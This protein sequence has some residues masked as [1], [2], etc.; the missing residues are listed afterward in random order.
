[1]GLLRE[2]DMRVSDV[3]EAVG[4]HDARYF[5]R[6]FRRLAGMTPAEYREQAGTE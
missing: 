3:A 2:G 1:M 6:V 4:I 5:T